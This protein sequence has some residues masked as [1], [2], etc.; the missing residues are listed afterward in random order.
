M[1]Q[2][3]W[4]LVFRLMTPTF[5]FYARFHPSFYADTH[6]LYHLSSVYLQGRRKVW[7]SWGASGGH[8][9]PLLVEI[10]L[11]DLQKSMGAAMV[12]PAHLAP[13]GLYCRRKVA[14]D[15]F[16]GQSR[17]VCIARLSKPIKNGIET[18]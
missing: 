5:P 4:M 12:P 7:K 1:Y 8:N 16:S 18:S 9:L 10:G 13:T 2:Q 3:N 14:K 17:L 15:I 11:T 6:N